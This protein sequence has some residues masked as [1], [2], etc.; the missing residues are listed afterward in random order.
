MT[1]QMLREVGFRRAHSATIFTLMH[2]R[3][4][5]HVMKYLSQNSGELQRM[6]RGI[7]CRRAPASALM[8][9]EKGA[10]EP[11]TRRRC[12]GGLC[13]PS[14]KSSWRMGGLPDGLATLYMRRY[15]GIFASTESLEEYKEVSKPMLGILSCAAAPVPGTT[16]GC[17]PKQRRWP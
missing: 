4:L 17:C 6:H 7:A 9:S 5:R 13:R 3:V 14:M 10:G 1:G 12:E 11:R 2:P 16:E 8:P 15:E